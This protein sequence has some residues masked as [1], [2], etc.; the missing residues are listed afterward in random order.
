ML[1]PWM[2]LPL[3]VT[4][5]QGSAHGSAAKV[6]ATLLPF[7]VPQVPPSIRE[8][9]RITNVS[10]LAGQP[11]TLECDTNGFPAP[12]VAWFK[13]GQLVGNSGEAGMERVAL[14]NRDVSLCAEGRGNVTDVFGDARVRGQWELWS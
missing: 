4:G 6:G 2:Q 12:E 10:G 11:L 7:L 9:G 8:E 1:A 13:D 3:W 14:Q 5:P